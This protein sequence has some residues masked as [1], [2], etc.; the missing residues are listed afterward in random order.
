MADSEVVLITGAS[1]GIG[2]E[3][4]RHYLAR[5]CRVVGCSRGPAPGA[6]A[7]APGYDHHQ[8]DVT[9]E[10]AVAAMIRAIS[11]KH[12]RLDILI[13]NAGIASMNLAL[14]TPGTTAER[15]MATNFVGSFLVAKEAA[16]LMM[17]RRYGRII[18]FST[19]AVPLGLE[20]ESIYAAS[21]GAVVT[22]TRVLAKELAPFG[23]TVNAV[24]PGPIRTDLIAGVPEAKLQALVDRLPTKQFSTFADVAN[25]VDFFARPESLAITGQVLYL[26]GA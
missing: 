17:R 8:V 3:L 23:I 13:N 9:D 18:N 15:L 1:R 6:E 12:G 22:F 4:V 5:G 14:T 10:A 24:G 20:G 2:R 19:V 21:K 16:K 7:Q 25:V 11:R 26:G